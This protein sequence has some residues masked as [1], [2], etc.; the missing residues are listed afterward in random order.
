M[1]GLM[2]FQYKINE[3]SYVVVDDANGVYTGQLF[4]KG[5]SY[6]MMSNTTETLIEMEKWIE[7]LKGVLNG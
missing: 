2:K 1:V 6:N 3:Q 4:K 7:K 5:C